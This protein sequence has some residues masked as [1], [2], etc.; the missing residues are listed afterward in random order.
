MG[1]QRA[2]HA[3][4][5]VIATVLTL[6]LLAG[7]QASTEPTSEDDSEPPEQAQDT[8]APSALDDV[9]FFGY[10]IQDQHMDGAI[11]EI[12]ASDYDIVIID[13]TRSIV[14]EE[15]YDSA[16]DV[17]RIK[18]SPGRN[19]ENKI[20][21]AYIDV[22]EAESYRTYWQ[23]EWEVG[24]PE[25]IVAPDPDGWDEN[26]P[27][28]YWDDEW[29]EIMYGA[30]DSLVEDGYDGAYLDWL[31][32]Y[33][34]EPVKEAAAA[35]GLDSEAELTSF[36]EDLADHARDQD[37]GFLMIAQNAAEM[38]KHSEY[39]EVFDAIAQEAIWFDGVGDPDQPEQTGDMSID[40]IFL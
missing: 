9:E 38:G 22:G 35:D 1:Q 37:P 11:D 33:K 17:A 32:A 2:W 6:A 29:R 24:D 18:S 4:L 19:V 23:D 20:V 36:V 15:E 7:C 10:Q 31:E 39:V 21:V 13:Q 40:Q 34:F 16:A 5:I 25:W 28:A 14:G 8:D 12:V 26:Y 27:V 30:F 3:P